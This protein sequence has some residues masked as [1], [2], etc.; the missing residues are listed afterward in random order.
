MKHLFENAG[1]WLLFQPLTNNA[2]FGTASTPPTRKNPPRRF[3]IDGLPP[4]KDRVIYW[5][6]LLTDDGD[7]SDKHLLSDILSE[8]GYGPN[9]EGLRS[10]IDS[11]LSTLPHFHK[12]PILRC[13]PDVGSRKTWVATYCYGW[14]SK[15]IAKYIEMMIEFR[16]QYATIQ[17][18][19][20]D[21]DKMFESDSKKVK[22]FINKALGK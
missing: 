6:Q 10:T 18:W 9:D 17:E 2:E 15:I 20:K 7:L 3:N 21:I 14:Q 5:G 8:E 13:Y 11:Y 1:E 4:I 19:A 12:M 16:A 22:E